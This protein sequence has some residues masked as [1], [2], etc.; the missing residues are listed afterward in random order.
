VVNIIRQRQV[1]R[2]FPGLTEA[3]LYLWIMDHRHYLNQ[4]YGTEVGAEAAATD[5]AVRLGRRD[6]RQWLGTA[7]QALRARLLSLFRSTDLSD[8]AERTGNGGAS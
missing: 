1:L 5:F 7:L 4:E 2:H 3:D 6:L 8:N